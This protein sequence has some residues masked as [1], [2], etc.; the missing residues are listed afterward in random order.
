MCSLQGGYA[1][2]TLIAPEGTPREIDVLR[3][4]AGG[5]RNKNIA[6]RLFISEETS[7]FT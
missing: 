7:R 4:V 3:Q 5:N 6:E 1:T 2:L